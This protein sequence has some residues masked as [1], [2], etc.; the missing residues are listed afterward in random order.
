[1]SKDK[2]AKNGKAAKKVLYSDKE[3][4]TSNKQ[5]TYVGEYQKE[6][7]FPIGGIGTGSIGLSGSGALV[8]WEIFNRPNKDYALPFSFFSIWAK[9]KGKESIAK[10]LQSP[11][12]PPYYRYREIDGVNR[13]T[14]AGLPHMDSCV[15]KGEYPFANIKFK[16]SQVP[17]EVSLEAYNPFIPLN[18]DDSSIPVAIFNFT[19]KNTK[20]TEV[21]ATIAANI[22]NDVGHSNYE[23]N[24]NK[25][26]GQNVNKYIKEKGLSGLFMTSK[27]YD[28][29][30]PNF[31]SLA[32]T[33]SHNNIVYQSYWFRGAWFDNFHYFWDEFSKDGMLKERNYDEPSPDRKSDVGSIG[34][35]VKLK[36]GESVT[37]PIYISWYS[38]NFQNYHET[39][40]GNP[41]DCKN[42]TW[43]NYYAT[44]FK[45][46]FD[47]A[48]YTAKESDRLYR[49]SKLFHDTLFSSSLPDYVIDAISSQA[50]ILKTT[51]CIRLE[52][53][54]FYGY[55]GCKTC[56]G[57]CGGSCTH[58]WN[59]AH[60]LAFLFPSLERSM[61]E[62]DYEY[63]QAE[64]GRMRFRLPLPRIK[65]NTWPEKGR[66]AADGQ[67]GGIMKFYRDW[68]LC[69]DDKWL[70]KLWPKVKLS[71]ES[72]W[73]EWD[74]DKDG[75]MEG[76]QHNTYDIEFHGANSLMGGFYLGAL[77]AAETIARY[78][79]E[80]DKANEYRSIF[81]KGKKK[82]DEKYFNGEFYIQ[83]YDPK[84][85][86]KYQY[87]KGCLS[88][89]MIGQW[90]S[91]IIGLGYLFKEANVKKSMES[92]FKYNWKTD[93]KDHANC[94]RIYAIN[95]DKGLL[96]CSWPK[97]G[98]PAIPFPYS[99]EVW[100]GIEYQV[101][102]HLIYE[103]YLKEGLSI[104]KG[105]R[106]RHDGKKRNPWNEFECGYHYA[107]SMA[108]Y[109][110]LNALSGFLYSAPQK[111]IS[112]NPQLN[113]KDFNVF[114][115]VGSGWGLYS[116]KISGNKMKISLD[117]KYG[118][119]TISKLNINPTHSVKKISAECNGSAI[120]VSFEK[121][122]NN[123]SIVFENPIS[124]KPDS[125]LKI[126]VE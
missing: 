125:S 84:E 105:V 109:S 85:G 87:G 72:A 4:F 12:T 122:K 51:T 65:L 94:Q 47:V 80:E 7:I 52:D 64:D 19:L 16:D 113:A 83:D 14:G 13:E 79:G 73:I 120:K 62:A 42:K 88:D 97:G 58:V 81:E 82:M 61:R 86:L 98:R 8:D 35:R 115:S 68:Q 44:Q 48:K 22:S 10:V 29:N 18:A 69:G 55:E 43:K 27:K 67:M 95:D 17:L 116:Q 32:L 46:A 119:L 26:L 104:V 78:L 36:P 28:E 100:C 90:F 126:L 111:S 34:L 99:D 6:V 75:V 25:Y 102:S 41:E 117:I 91:H 24:E 89:Q 49:E 77:K 66:P 15:F 1:M 39:Y 20:K 33:T 106:D 40:W 74:K 5:K 92:T 53:G 70:K 103:G 93:F 50:S 71:L 101:A 57:C 118:N 60:T 59:Y 54:T 114:F 30:S 112:F 21:E 3:L 37:L 38:P 107:R 56:S 2:L 63:N 108:S 123:C 11:A 9:E 96:L 76:I 23:K 110:V 121:D 31:G 45:D 124:I